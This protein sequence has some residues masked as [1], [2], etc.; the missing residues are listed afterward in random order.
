MSA[1]Q[2]HAASGV[3]APCLSVDTTAAR[4]RVV[5]STAAAHRSDIKVAWGTTA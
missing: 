2:A 1:P 3:H 5:L 4:L